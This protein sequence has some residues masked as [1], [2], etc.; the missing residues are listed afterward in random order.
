MQRLIHASY[1]HSYEDAQPTL[2]LGDTDAQK[3]LHDMTK[4]F[5]QPASHGVPERSTTL[6]ATLAI[7]ALKTRA[8]GVTANMMRH[9]Q[10]LGMQPCLASV[11][12]YPVPTL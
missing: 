1:T 10:V 2:C 3:Q 7:K 5:S 9:K 6:A 11:V 12:H 4:L 8:A